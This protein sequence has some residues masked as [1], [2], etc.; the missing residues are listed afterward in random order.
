MT[1]KINTLLILICIMSIS[2]CT[3]NRNS[4]FPAAPVGDKHT[5][6]KLADAYRIESTRLPSS[7]SF[8]TPKAKKIFVRNIFRRAGF[9]YKKTLAV[10]ADTKKENI[11][12]LDKDLAELLSIP[13]QGLNS[14][15]KL[16]IYSE[17][18]MVLVNK[19]DSLL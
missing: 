19:I 11:T 1:N 8:I 15:G 3:D 5:L 12:R 17:S 9:S 13:H 18:E 2:A 16:E 4:D 14:E 10:V 6:E 7:L